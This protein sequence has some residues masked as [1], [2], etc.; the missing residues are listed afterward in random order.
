MM[1]GKR[2]VARLI[3]LVLL[4]AAFLV[5]FAA[6]MLAL[7]AAAPAAQAPLKE[8]RMP[9]TLRRVSYALLLV[10]MLGLASGWLGAA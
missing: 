3:L 6:A 8:D 5:A 7:R 2:G 4:L 9:T 10:L 1:K